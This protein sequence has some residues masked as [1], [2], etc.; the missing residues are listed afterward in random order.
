MT[1]SEDEPTPP[2]TGSQ[3][4][5]AIWYYEKNGM[6]PVGPVSEDSIKL[7][8]DAK[9]IHNN[10]RVWTKAFGNEW[11]AIK[12]TDLYYSGDGPP[13]LATEE[14]NNIAAWLIAITPL[15]GVILSVPF[16]ATSAS[17]LI[18]IDSLLYIGLFIIDQTFIKRSGRDPFDIWNVVPIILLAI[19][20]V[21]AYLYNRAERTGQ[22]LAIFWTSI[23]VFVPFIVSF[24]ITAI[25]S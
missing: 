11:K 16:V 19:L 13:P 15:L 12:D 6:Q 18:G 2:A 17:V 20:F 8:L 23:V 14:V 5:D 10:T 25:H 7:L 3:S 21:P 1:S 4:T 9:T 22:S 24:V